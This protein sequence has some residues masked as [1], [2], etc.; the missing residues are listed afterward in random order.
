[1]VGLDVCSTLVNPGVIFKVTPLGSLSVVHGMEGGLAYPTGPL[2]LGSDGA[3]Y[4]T[5]TQGGGDPFFGGGGSV[6]RL[7]PDGGF[8]FVTVGGGAQGAMACCQLWQ[9]PR[10]A[11]VGVTSG[12]INLEALP[13]NA[14]VFAYSAGLP[15]AVPSV[16]MLRP[17]AGPVGSLI[18][19]RGDHFIHVQQ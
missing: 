2:L 15:P 9:D 3:W 19:I 8:T 17:G 16:T 12:N 10:G 13:D 14:T 7:A 11:I 4:G 18:V 1:S 6:L 5:T